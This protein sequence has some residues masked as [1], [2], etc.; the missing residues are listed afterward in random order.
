M[1]TQYKH[2]Y[3]I[4]YIILLGTRYFIS[5]FKMILLQNSEKI[6]IIIKYRYIMFIL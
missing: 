4:L 2:K 3:N 1:G 5:S 6:Y